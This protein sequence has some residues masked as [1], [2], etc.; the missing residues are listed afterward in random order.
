MFVTKTSA[1]KKNGCGQHS[2]RKRI[3]PWPSCCCR[4]VAVGCVNNNLFMSLPLKYFLLRQTATV[5][6]S[7]IFILHTHTHSRI[8]RFFSFH[9]FFY[10]LQSLGFII[11]SFIDD[12]NFKFFSKH[13]QTNTH[14]RTYTQCSSRRNLVAA[15]AFADAVLP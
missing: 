7:W 2:G 4:V 3:L 9:T 13:S 11:D 10:L 12:T 5:S 1:K 6:P 8:I 14:T 15:S